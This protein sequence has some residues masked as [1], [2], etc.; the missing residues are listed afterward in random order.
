[1]SKRLLFLSLLTSVVLAGQQSSHPD[2]QTF[3]ARTAGLRKVDGFFPL[4]WDEHTGKMWL[5]I[6]RFDQEFL[7]I[8]A[9][10]AGVGSNELGL[11]R[12]NIDPPMVVQFERSGPRVLL[13]ESNYDFRVTSA[14]A[15][16]RRAERD[17]FARS[18]LW[19]FEVAAE[20]G[21]RVLVDATNFFQRD[22][23]HVSE[24]LQKQKQGQYHVDPTR[25][26]FYLPLTKG[27]PKNTEVETTITF[28]GEATGTYIREVTPSP[29]AVTVRQHQSLVAL[30]GPG[31]KPRR[32]DPRAGY[33][34]T[35]FM[36]FSAPLDQPVM[37][38]YIARHRLE[39]KDPNASL[40]DPVQPIVYYVDPGAPSDIR[41]AL[42]EGARWWSQAFEVAGFH[43]AFQVSMLPPES[44]P[45]DVRYNVIQWV[46]RSTRGWSY[47]N[48][49]VDPRTG[50]IIKGV[51]S[52]G[53]LREHQ[54]YLIFEG[55]MAPHVPGHD[56]TAVLEN[57]VYARLRQLAAHEVGH[58]LGLEHNYIASTQG[59]ASVMDY[60]A[61]LVDVRPDD[62][63]DLSNSY[64]TGIGEWDKIAIRWGY[65]QF[66]D[67]TDEHQALNKIIADAAKRGLT[68]VTDADSRPPGS[69][70]PQSHLWDNGT[71]AVD[72]LKRV[73]RIRSIALS[74][75]GENNI[76]L[77]A[78][79]ASLD[80]VLVP[81]YFLHRYQ[82]QAASKV[83]GGNE[84]SYALRGDG[85]PITHIV[86]ATEQR[87]ALQVLLQTID[88][89]TLTLPSR[90]L[91]LIPP[92]PPGYPRTAET[93]P[94][95]TGVTFDPVSAAETAADMTISLILNSQRAARLVQ[96]HAENQENPDLREVILNLIQAT[97]GRAHETGLRLEVIKAV[98]YV[99]VVR[100][101]GLAL[102]SSAP[103]E[104]RSIATDG[105]EQLKS[106]AAA[107]RYVL[108]L[109]DTFE[110]DPESLDLPS[111][112]EPPPGQPIGED[113]DVSGFS[114]SQS[115]RQ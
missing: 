82:T 39:K 106:A 58:T 2:E 29:D 107:D 109:I 20:D 108:R 70:H 19:G 3:A 52:L 23:A 28:T 80:E 59:R 72:E 95:R 113:E 96:Y 105:V 63:F 97:W 36:D 112:L 83:L 94:S 5:E 110:R 61:P 51:V 65:S 26:A 101:I 32:Q 41:A 69:A 33:F 98:N 47:G 46:H 77:G 87:R 25:T 14:D 44:D 78:P 24:R 37:K 1:M 12:G 75:F 79:L 50:E 66:P 71:N 99:V 6:D 10:S 30:P 49:L 34:A 81:L 31:F 73:L 114:V 17:S 43:N 60:P 115:H 104:V 62:T 111:P 57:A 53:S 42:I 64:A 7:Y 56:T 67:G 103:A 93:F 9:L 35:E 4:Y 74:R 13:I 21:P 27:F 38:R 18:T 88:P 90:I 85:Q 76:Q 54:D 48:S 86:P 22:A 11:D 84:Y 40:S 15:A 68:F 16:E 100:L 89:N 91:D 92:R 55:L 45:M 8:T 102:D